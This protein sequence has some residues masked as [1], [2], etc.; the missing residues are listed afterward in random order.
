MGAECRDGVGGINSGGDGGGIGSGSASGT[1]V[2]GCERDWV[3]AGKIRGCV[4][5]GASGD[6]GDGTSGQAKRSGRNPQNLRWHPILGQHRN[7][8]L[9]MAGRGELLV[10]LHCV[11]PPALQPIFAIVAVECTAH[12]GSK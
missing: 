5:V 4:G 8:L 6:G 11:F 7:G 10:L 1:Q 2:G 12:T 3:A 9:R